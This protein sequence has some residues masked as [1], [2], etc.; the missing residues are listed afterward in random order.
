MALRWIAAGVLEAEHRFR[1]MSGHRDPV[2]SSERLSVIRREVAEGRQK[3][4]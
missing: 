4:A 3:T 1:K 2:S